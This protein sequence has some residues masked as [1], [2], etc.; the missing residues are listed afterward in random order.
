MQRY[1]Y[2]KVRTYKKDNY[3]EVRNFQEDLAVVSKN[4]KYGFINKNGKEVIPRIY[5]DA[6]D[7]SEGLAAVLKNEKYGFID[8]QGQEVIPCIYDD[9]FDFSEGLAAVLKNGKCGFIDKQGQEVIPCIYD[10]ARSFHEGL[11]AVMKNNRW[12]FLNKDGKEAFKCNL[13]EE[14]ED[15]REGLVEIYSF[16]FLEN[17]YLN[18][19]GDLVFSCSSESEGF[20]EG[21]ACIRKKCYNGFI[22]RFG[23]EVIPCIY[24]LAKSFHEGLACVKNSQNGKYGF[25]DKDGQE[26][27]EFK[28]CEARSFH[29]GLAYV[30]TKNNVGFINKNGEQLISYDYNY[31][32]LK[33]FHEERAAIKDKRKNKCGFINKDGEIV[34]PCIYEQVFDFQEGFAFVVKNSRCFFIDREGKE[35][36]FKNLK[37]KEEILYVQDLQDIPS[38]YFN[39]EILEYVSAFKTNSSEIVFV[40]ES[41][42][43]KYLESLISVYKAIQLQ[44]ES[45]FFEDILDKQFIKK[46]KR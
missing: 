22:N 35:L 8:K 15:F 29:E 36:E 43:N 23:K 6:F 46:I 5:D 20:R 40:S 2:L 10:N 9:V 7:F 42:Y 45:E 38:E 26:V 4:E 31:Y 28:Y 39:P 13:L 25:I 34:V 3:D 24:E 18:E 32:F 37:N 16:Q 44:E 17:M 11:V 19:N 33:D 1:D 27:I 30:R 14:P 21:L 12:S 41:D